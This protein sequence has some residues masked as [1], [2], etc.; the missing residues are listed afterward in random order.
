MHNLSSRAPMRGQAHG[1]ELFGKGASGRGAVA[2]CLRRG[3]SRD[4]RPHPARRA[5]H[6]VGTALML[7][8][9]LGCHGTESG[10]NASPCA[11]SWLAASSWRKGTST[12]MHNP[13][14]L[15]TPCAALQRNYGSGVGGAG[16]SCMRVLRGGRDEAETSAKEAA[17]VSE[18]E[19]VL[20]KRSGGPEAVLVR[21][22]GG[23]EGAD[24]KDMSKL[25]LLLQRAAAYSG[26]LR[27]RLQQSRAILNQVRA[28]MHES[29]SGVSNTRIPYIGASV[30]IQSPFSI[31]CACACT[32]LCMH[33][34]LCRLSVSLCLSVSVVLSVPKP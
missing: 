5:C 24:A 16:V 11:P 17:R 22:E 28:C 21:R 33:E 18:G 20:G 13:G 9:L 3:C 25:G 32:I 29:Q 27:E 23:E 6:G 7:M 2:L 1:G 26:F 19:S 10:G 8:V 12:S 34:S 31:R 30:L 14:T 15:I 4:G